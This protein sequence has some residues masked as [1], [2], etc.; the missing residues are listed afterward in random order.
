MG[1]KAPAT[2]LAVFLLGVTLSV[3]HHFFY[4]AANGTAPSLNTYDVLGFSFSTQQIHIAAGTAFA[5][6]V[7]SFLAAAI[8]IAYT[9]CFWQSMK[10]R[11]SS[12]SS[13][14]T[15]WSGLR[16]ILSLVYIWRWAKYPVLLI[17][18]LVAW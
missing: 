6:L 11:T 1:W 9:Q 15:L 10:N 16:N 13:V 4:A 3:G 8:T 12:V 14:D 17:I 18:A 5:F 2:M 7:K